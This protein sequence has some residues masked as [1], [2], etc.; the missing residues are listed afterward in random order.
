MQVL[1]SF[2]T[3]PLAPPQDEHSLGRGGVVCGSDVAAGNEVVGVDD[4]LE[5]HLDLG[6]VLRGVE[7]DEPFPSRALI[8][9]GVRNR[10][11]GCSGTAGATRFQ[12]GVQTTIGMDV[13]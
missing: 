12:R 11:T 1:S 9:P 7:H 8:G 10:L 2:G 5:N 4:E 6:G 13:R 3:A